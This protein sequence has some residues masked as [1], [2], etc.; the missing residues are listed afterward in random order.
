ML[1]RQSLSKIRVGLRAARPSP[2]IPPHKREGNTS[3]RKAAGG[4]E[5]EFLGRRLAAEDA[6]A[7][8][9]AAEFGDDVE[10]ELAPNRSSPKARAW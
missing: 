10:M 2:L 7:M 9:E 5:G 1:R 6:I 4:E 3:P 8:R